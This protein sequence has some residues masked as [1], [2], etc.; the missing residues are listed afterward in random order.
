[1]TAFSTFAQQ[2]VTIE[3]QTRPLNSSVASLPRTTNYTR[4]STG[5]FMFL[6]YATAETQLDQGSESDIGGKLLTKTWLLNAC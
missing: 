2:A 6:K 5:N 4:V 1:M 3:L